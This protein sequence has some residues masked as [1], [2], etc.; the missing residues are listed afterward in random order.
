[1]AR[2]SPAGPGAAGHEVAVRA[3]A[4]GIGHGIASHRYGW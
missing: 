1:M 4:G 2:L 3:V